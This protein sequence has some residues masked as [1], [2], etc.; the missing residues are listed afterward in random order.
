MAIVDFSA[1][2]R[3]SA[4]I[5]ERFRV[6]RPGPDGKPELVSPGGWNAMLAIRM[7][8]HAQKL[9]ILENAIDMPLVILFATLP[10]EVQTQIFKAATEAF[11]QEVTR[12]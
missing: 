10:E 6:E 2:M 5:E 1:N 4:A 12:G 8:P 11:L 7:M 3:P 9:E